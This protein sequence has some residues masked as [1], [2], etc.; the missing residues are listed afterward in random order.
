MRLTL[1]MLLAV[2]RVRRSPAAPRGPRTRLLNLGYTLHALVWPHPGSVGFFP[3]Q[4]G[5]LSWGG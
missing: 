3:G 1:A 5:Q 2:H 4:A